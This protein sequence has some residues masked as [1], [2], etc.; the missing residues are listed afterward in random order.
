VTIFT[1]ALRIASVGIL[2]Q[3]FGSKVAEGFF[4]DFSG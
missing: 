1:N 2:Y 3:F 4:H